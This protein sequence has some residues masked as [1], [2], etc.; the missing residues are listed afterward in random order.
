MYIYENKYLP[1]CF[2]GT[3]TKNQEVHHYNTR[4]A[5]HYRTIKYISD[6]MKY[7]ITIKGPN[8]WKEILQ[9]IK[10]SLSLHMFKKSIKLL[11]L[12]QYSNN[13]P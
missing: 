12:N 1:K 10:S 11:L 7:S 2:V 6:K 13:N 8:I 4:F 5:H 3:F 9:K